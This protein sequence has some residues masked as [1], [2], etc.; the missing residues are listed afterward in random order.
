VPATEAPTG[1]P[2]V[3]DALAWVLLLPATE[4][5]GMGEEADVSF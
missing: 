4:V 5:D 1:L 2:A 3:V